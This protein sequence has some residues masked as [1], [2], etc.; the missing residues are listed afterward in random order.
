MLGPGQSDEGRVALAQRRPR[1]RA[2]ALEA[3]PQVGRQAQL[4]LVAFGARD[5]RCRS[6]EPPYSQ[7]TGDA[8]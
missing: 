4:L 8:P 7:R 2:A 1:A 5:A 3:E 6:R